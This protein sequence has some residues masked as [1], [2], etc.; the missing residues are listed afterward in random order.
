MRRQ[1]IRCALSAKASEERLLLLD[2]LE[3]G[4]A[5]TKAMAAVLKALAVSSSALVVLREP[6]ED[7]VR[8]VRN[9]PRIKTL[10]ADL[11]NVLDLSRYDV[12]LMTEDAAK[13]TEELWADPKVKRGEAVSA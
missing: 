3:L 2:K 11:L 7:V 12:V 8:A 6:Q 9:L 5:K 1:A 10:A 13:R 4:D